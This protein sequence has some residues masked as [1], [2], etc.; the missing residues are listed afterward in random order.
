M[1]SANFVAN[2]F[3]R[4]LLRFLSIPRKSEE[5]SGQVLNL[6]TIL[7]FISGVCIMTFC[8]NRPIFAFEGVMSADVIQEKI[9]AQEKNI[10]L[11]NWEES[12][13]KKYNGKK[14]YFKT[15]GVAH[16]K[17]TEY[18]NGYP[19]KINIVEINPNINKNL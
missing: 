18:I 9:D 7:L 10:E 3:A 17:T 4:P 5:D 12:I 16:I 15:S 19:T 2:I 6:I 11:I 1:A 13:L 8:L 14:V